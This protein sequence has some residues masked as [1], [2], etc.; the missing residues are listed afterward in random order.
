MPVKAVSHWKWV[1][2]LSLTVTFMWTALWVWSVIEIRGKAPLVMGSCYRVSFM[3]I[4]GSLSIN[5]EPN[6]A[7]PP[8]WPQVV[9]HRMTLPNRY[10]TARLRSNFFL[11][12]ISNQPRPSVTFPISLPI[13]LSLLLTIWLWRRAQPPHPP[14]CCAVCGYCLSG[15]AHA[16]C[17]ECG[18]N[19]VTPL[20][21]YSGKSRSSNFVAVS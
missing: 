8:V 16:R 9:V 10:L 7:G 20:I 17:P 18:S 3:M 4:Y 11:P 15:A 2:R 1:K 21:D 14:E 12:S 5:W 13:A 6:G 19:T